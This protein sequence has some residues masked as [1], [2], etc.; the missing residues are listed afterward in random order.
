METIITMEDFQ[1]LKFLLCCSLLFSPEKWHNPDF[2]DIFNS[3]L[4]GLEW[5]G[6]RGWARG[7]GC[8]RWTAA[9][10]F[11]VAVHEVR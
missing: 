6:R 4:L 8:K 10:R 2:I 11:G 1:V 9:P 5:G 3:Q 7:S